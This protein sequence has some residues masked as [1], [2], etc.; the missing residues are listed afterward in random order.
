MLALRKSWR[1]LGEGKCEFLAPENRKM[2]TYVLRHEQETLLVV[3][4]LSRFVQPVEL[5]LSAFKRSHAG[6]VVWPHGVPGH[7]ENLI[8]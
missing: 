4:N 6:R 2:L 8:F 1:A 5:D 7:T 3:A